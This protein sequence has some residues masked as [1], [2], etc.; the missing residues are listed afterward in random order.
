MGLIALFAFFTS[1]KIHLP[2]TNRVVIFSI[3][4]SF[5]LIIGLFWELW[6][7]FAG[8]SSVLN[9]LGDTILDLVMDT[10]G[11]IVAYLFA[12]NRIWIRN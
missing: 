7:L 9:D 3:T 12:V 6:E 10:V 4:V 1:G 11:A 5:V 2:Q 8:L